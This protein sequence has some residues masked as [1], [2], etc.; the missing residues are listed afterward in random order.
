MSQQEILEAIPH[1]KPMLLIDEIVSQT[2]DHIICKKTFDAEEFFYQGHY[3]EAPITPGII[4]CEAGMQAGAI[5]LSKLLADQEGVPVV[6]RLTNAKFKKM[7]RP[8]D[9]V[10]LEVHLGERLKNTYFMKAKVT[11]GEKL[12]VTFEFACTM[13]NA[14]L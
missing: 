4:L 7:V 1:R 2:E 13:A 8:G 3:P 10:S 9:T 6:T 14:K 12:A 5:L 11:N